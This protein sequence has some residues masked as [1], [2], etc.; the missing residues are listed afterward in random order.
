MDSDNSNNSED[1]TVANL[2][3]ATSNS[4]PHQFPK[5]F[6]LQDLVDLGLNQTRE[7][8]TGCGP[9]ACDSGALARLNEQGFKW[10]ANGEFTYG[11]CGSRCD[12]CLLQYGCDCAGSILSGHRGTV[13]RVAYRGPIDECCMTRLSTVGNTTCDPRYRNYNPS[14]DCDETM[15]RE[16]NVQD[17]WNTRPCIDWATEIINKNKTS[18]LSPLIDWCSKGDNFQT[19]ACVSVCSKLTDKGQKSLCDRP[20]QSYCN[21]HP[22][23]P[24]CECL[25][26]RK[27]RPVIDKLKVNASKACWYEPCKLDNTTL[28]MTADLARAFRDCRTTTCTINADGVKVDNRGKVIFNN[29]CGNEYLKPEF[30][31]DTSPTPTFPN[32]SILFGLGSLS[33]L[34][35]VVI[36]II[37]L[38]ILYSNK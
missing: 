6:K 33:I 7:M 27:I 11:G 12:L 5:E 32:Y 18:D 25:L 38:I 4:K 29:N 20:L 19:E 15:K 35:I 37:V 3:C 34:C 14:N 2:T 21:A 24:N 26:A 9:A 28:Y 23:D 16:C 31:P 22:N 1:V 13:K 17:K 10:P 36:C 8:V 30:I